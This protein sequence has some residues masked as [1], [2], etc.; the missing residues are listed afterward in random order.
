MFQSLTSGKLLKKLLVDQ[1]FI[2][3]YM[4]GLLTGD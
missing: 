2:V 3:R 4:L 1:L